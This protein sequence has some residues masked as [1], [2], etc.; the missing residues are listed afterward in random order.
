[1]LISFSLD[2]VV[3]LFSL[4][5]GHLNRKCSIFSWSEEVEGKSAMKLCNRD[6]LKINGVHPVWSSLPAVTREVKK[7]QIKTRLL[8]GTYLLQSD[9]IG[10]KLYKSSI[11][12]ILEKKSFPGCFY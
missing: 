5:A 6:I 11:S 10:G 8:T 4:R 9:R 12:C 7:A 3:F 2:S 1:M